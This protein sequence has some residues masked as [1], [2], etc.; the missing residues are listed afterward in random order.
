M[1]KFFL[2]VLGM[3]LLQASAGQQLRIDSLN[4]VLTATARPVDSFS[5]MVRFLEQSLLLDGGKI[6]SAMVVRLLT[7]A[8]REKND[9]LLAISYNWIGSYLAF[10][11][12]TILPDWNIILKPSR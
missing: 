3:A 7:I 1:K 9:S 4:R 5:T 8:R 10:V 6:D 2:F 11:R 12:E